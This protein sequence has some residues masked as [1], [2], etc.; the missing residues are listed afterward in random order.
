M[1]FFP[2]FYLK[3]HS[4]I[5]LVRKMK[6]SLHSKIIKLNKNRIREQK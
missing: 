6:K 3:I 2:I 4:N 5:N 1:I